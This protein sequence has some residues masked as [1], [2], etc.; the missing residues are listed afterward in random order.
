MRYIA[1]WLGFKWDPMLDPKLLEYYQVTFSTLQG[2]AVLKD[3]MDRVYCTVYEGSDPI[4]MAQ[5][6]GR[7]SVVDDILRNIDGAEFPNKYQIKM[8]ASNGFDR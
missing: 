8:E 7:R 1:R 2:G 3:L 5:H 4:L 6:N